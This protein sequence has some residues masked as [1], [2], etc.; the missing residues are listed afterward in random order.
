[1]RNS[2][3]MSLLS[4]ESES[5]KSI[6]NRKKNHSRRIVL[7]MLSRQRAMRRDSEQKCFIIQKVMTSEPMVTAKALLRRSVNILRRATST[8]D[9]DTF[10]KYR[11][12]PPISIAILLQK[13]ALLL[14]ESGIYTTNLYHDTP[15]IC[16]AVLLQK[17]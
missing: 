7:A 12:T 6:Q 1:M 13:Y 8:P 5:T 4:R 14:A 3:K 11:C 17:H 15:P 2:L 16:I 9:P 10:E